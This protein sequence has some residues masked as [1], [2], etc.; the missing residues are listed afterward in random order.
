MKGFLY[1]FTFQSGSIQMIIANK[2]FHITKNFTFQSGSIQIR[3]SRERLA[4][5]QSFTFQ[6]GSI[7]IMREREIEEYLRLFTFQSGSIQMVFKAQY[8]DGFVLPLHSNLVLFKCLKTGKIQTK[9]YLYIPIWFYSNEWKGKMLGR[10]GHF[11]F[12]SGSIQITQLLDNEG[13][14]TTLHSNLVLFK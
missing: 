2:N 13:D 1:H 3:T 7:Q 5:T 8:H 4:K 14:K 9:A 6:S 10:D 12:Q 11:T